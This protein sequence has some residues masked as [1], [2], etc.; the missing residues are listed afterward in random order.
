MTLN[1]AQLE[2]VVELAQD[3]FPQ[4]ALY[5]AQAYSEPTEVVA[6]SEVVAMP[7]AVKFVKSMLQSILIKLNIG[8]ISKL[9]SRVASALFS[10]ELDKQQV[11]AIAMK[12]VKIMMLVV[13]IIAPILIYLVLKA[14]GATPG[15]EGEGGALPGGGNDPAL[16]Y[17]GMAQDNLA[18]LKLAIQRLA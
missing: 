13:A 16:P 6:G 17:I 5:L 7:S 1:K 14:R 12:Y 10:Q 3:G 15:D 18:E 8:S 4:E 2:A 9:I 11:K